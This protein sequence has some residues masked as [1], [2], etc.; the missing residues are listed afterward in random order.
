MTKNREAGR[1]QKTGRFVD[2]IRK[3][4]GRPDT[5]RLVDEIDKLK[6]SDD[7]TSTTASAP[8]T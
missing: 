1:S 6:I 5:E 8:P 3:L 2:A 7:L 4:R